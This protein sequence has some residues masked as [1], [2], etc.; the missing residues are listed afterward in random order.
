[1]SFSVLVNF[2]PFFEGS[3][4]YHYG[5]ASILLVEEGITKSNPFLEKDGFLVDNWLLTDQKEMIPMSGQGLITL[6]GIFY[7][8]GG[9]FGLYYL[10]PIFFIILLITSER[11]ATNLFGK[12]VGLIALILLSTSNLLF[13][14]SIQLQTESIFCL[15]FILGAYFLIKFGKTNKSYLILI[16]LLGIIN[17]N[18]KLAYSLIE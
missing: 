13:R 2:I 4:S 12:Y 3:N 16:F 9:Y 8:I 7:L 6:G 15:M 5:I 11:I 14:N 17:L 1:M 10:S 18:I